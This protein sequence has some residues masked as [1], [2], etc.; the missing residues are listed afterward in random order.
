MDNPRFTDREQICKKWNYRVSKKRNKSDK[1]KNKVK[2]QKLEV[3]MKRQY[4]SGT[5][6]GPPMS[7]IREPDG[8]NQEMYQDLLN[9]KICIGPY[10]ESHLLF[11]NVVNVDPP[12]YQGH[13]ESNILHQALCR[14]L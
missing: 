11:R 13:Q 8:D 2:L 9:E 14:F 12:G 6:G 4:S 10:Q 5:G 1:E 3:R 7:P